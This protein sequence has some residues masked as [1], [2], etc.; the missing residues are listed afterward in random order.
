VK[1]AADK[2]FKEPG[3]P[4]F[5]AVAQEF[6]ARLYRENEE[7]AIQEKIDRLR[8]LRLAN[9]SPD[10]PTKQRKPRTSKR[11]PATV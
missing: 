7:R 8:A 11:T 10:A 2:L 6:N 3:R 9:N 4:S 1:S 5:S